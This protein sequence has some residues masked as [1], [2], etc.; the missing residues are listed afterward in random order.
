MGRE[1]YVN[2]IEDMCDLMCPAPQ[3][4]GEIWYDGDT[5]TWQVEDATGEWLGS[6]RTYE[7]ALDIAVEF[8]LEI[9]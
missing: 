5:G 6:A 9:D 7:E 8:G 3:T 2:S 1:F 4:D